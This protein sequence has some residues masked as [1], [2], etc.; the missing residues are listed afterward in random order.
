MSND[1]QNK[2]ALQSDALSALVDVASKWLLL[3]PVLVMCRY[4]RRGGAAD[5]L[6]VRSPSE[7]QQQL[8]ALPIGTEVLVFAPSAMDSFVFV[9]GD[10][11]DLDERLARV[12]DAPIVL[13]IG[14]DYVPR[15][16]S[17]PSWTSAERDDDLR[18]IVRELLSR[19]SA[20]YVGPEPDYCSVLPEVLVS[21][22]IGG[23]SGPR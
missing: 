17:D 5:W 10:S 7:L 15:F 2:T 20:V 16:N 21:A 6:V 18:A 22:V 9:S 4:L 19:S 3:G 1:A 12:A 11:V 14:V 8:R 23:V 13:A